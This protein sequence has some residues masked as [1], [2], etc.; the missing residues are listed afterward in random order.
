M[1]SSDAERYMRL[2]LT[3]AERGVVRGELPFGAVLVDPAGE[4]VAGTHD[5]VRLDR[6]RTSHAE[7]MLIKHACRRF[8]PDLS[9]HIVVTTTEPCPMC[10]TTCWLAGVEAIVFGTTMDE[11]RTYTGGVVEELFVPA[12]S[13]NVQATRRVRLVGGVLRE[14]CLAL[15]ES[16]RLTVEVADK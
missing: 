9:D 16:H 4:V 15:F 1:T 13:L 11:V 6:D 10:F 14:R 2:A 5:T 7:T 3:E 8:G 12:E